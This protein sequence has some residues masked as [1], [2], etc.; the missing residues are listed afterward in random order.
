[1]IKGKKFIFNRPYLMGILNIT[2]DSFSDGG[3]HF[4]KEVAIKAAVEMIRKGADIL[5][6]G[7]ESS[8]PGSDPV[9]EEEE[10][11]RI[12]PVIEGILEIIPEAI[13]SVD[14]YKSRVA[15]KALKSGAAIINDI[16]GGRLDTQ[17]L[18]IISEYKAT[19]VLMH[20]RSIPKD[21]QSYT[22]YNNLIG[23]I[24]M[25]LEHRLQIA[26]SH[27]IGQII[28]DPGIGF[29]KTVDQ[30]YEIIKRLHEFTAFDCPLLIG[31]S[32][33]S[34]IGTSLNL[35]T[36]KRDFPSAIL[37]TISIMNGARIIRTHNVDNFLTVKKIF[38]H[39]YK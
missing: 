9:L 22:D 36:D 38:S 19:Y 13:I 17:I 31:L 35:A 39:I 25:S 7:G 5:D 24:K 37:E 6:I 26:K 32:R 2:P 4:D 30:N 28:V 15:E 8:R 34:F 18:D 3:L 16:T 33:K 1:M 14:T 29:A 11:R 23:E 21:M 27:N 10:I 12:I 20:S